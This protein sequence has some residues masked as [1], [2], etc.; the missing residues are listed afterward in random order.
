MTNAELNSRAIA[1]HCRRQ[2]VE[3][4]TQ[5]DEWRQEAARLRDALRQHPGTFARFLADED[6]REA[7]A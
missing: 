1:R 2:A 5:R 4:Q 7:S 6:A 3:M